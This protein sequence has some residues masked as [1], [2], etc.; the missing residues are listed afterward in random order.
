MNESII[1]RKAVGRNARIGQFYNVINEELPN[2]TLFN[3]FENNPH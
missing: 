3:F 2:I 1:I